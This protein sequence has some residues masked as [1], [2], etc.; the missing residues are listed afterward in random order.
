MDLRLRTI[1][2]PCVFAL[3]YFAF[4]L[5]AQRSIP[6]QGGPNGLLRTLT[7]V[8]EF[9][10]VSA[11]GD[12]DE[13]SFQQ[14]AP[15]LSRFFDGSKS[16]D[17]TEVGRDSGGQP[18]RGHPSSVAVSRDGRKLYITLPGNEAEPLNRL[19]V[20]DA[21]KGAILKVLRVGSAPFAAVLHP[22]NDLLFITHLYS[23]FI[24]IIDTQ[25]DI[26]VARVPLTTASGTRFYAQKIAFIRGGEQLLV[27]NRMT[28]SLLVYDL[29]RRRLSFVA[30]IPLSVTNNPIDSGDE[31]RDGPFNISSDV[32]HLDPSIDGL[33]ANS[34][35]RGLVRN[36]SNV[37]PRDVVVFENVWLRPGYLTDLAYVANV[38][39]LGVSI[40]DI[41][42]ARQIDSIDLNSPALGLAKEETTVSFRGKQRRLLFI[43]TGGRFAGGLADIASE[44]AVVSVDVDPLS[45]SVRY[46]SAPQLPVGPSGGPATGVPVAPTADAPYLS[47]FATTTGARNGDNPNGSRDRL[48]E[49]LGGALPFQLAAADGFLFVIYAA[50]DQIELFSINPQPRTPA[51]TL[52]RKVVR[53][54]NSGQVAFPTARLQALLETK[55]NSGGLLDYPIFENGSAVSGDI[56]AAEAITGEREP[57]FFDGRHPHGIVV[58]A[59]TRRV[60][61]ANRLGE[62]VSAFEYSQDG[63]LVPA[64]V[65]SLDLR[66]AIGPPQ[67]TPRFPATLAE[68]GED[69]YTSSRVTLNRRQACLSCHPDTN[70]DSKSWAVSAAPGGVRRRVQTNRNLRDTAPYGFAGSRSNLEICARNLRAFSPDSFFGASLLPEHHAFRDANG[71]GRKDLR[72]WGRPQADINRNAMYVLERTGVGFEYVSA[73]IAAF[74]EVEPRLL[75]NPFRTANESLAR[76]VPINAGGAL[77]F[78]DAVRGESLFRQLG[79]ASCHPAPLFTTNRTFTRYSSVMRDGFALADLTGTSILDGVVLS[80]EESVFGSGAMDEWVDPRLLP[81]TERNA[82]M[83]GSRAFPLERSIENAIDLDARLFFAATPN[84]ST[85]DYSF[86]ASIPR[87]PFSRGRQLAGEAGHMPDRN[88]SSTGADGRNVNVPSLRNAWEAAPYLHHGRAAS[89]LDVLDPDA[90]F[91][92]R[93]DADTGALVKRPPIRHGAIE[94]LRGRAAD[95][96]DLAA[97]IMSIQ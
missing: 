70:T 97:F 58:H 52:A 3:S 68:M 19:A 24:S 38:N 76:R 17:F 55:F 14:H 2:A 69:F 86:P 81:T 18:L 20:V 73:A 93:R 34:N 46:T 48:P 35:P 21:E 49:L 78:G 77:L 60:Y 32:D 83:Q 10:R 82:R 36:L 47:A 28:D 22:R 63:F 15:F 57:G 50:S 5:Y 62:S 74:L 56:R 37:N 6:S 66:A 16:I 53:Y 27:T 12:P 95:R 84:F 67:A 39:G 87:S 40:V 61:V 42:A 65:A 92:F 64:S 29:D 43:A 72:D 13:G 7:P 45:L 1:V 90:E 41:R 44:L 89:L 33:T 26:E 79:C 94:S 11:P 88:V 54:T 80:H 51:D 4:L 59:A 30:E 71:D 9:A 75:P 85:F 31:P 23:S 91:N 96:L 8:A 25:R